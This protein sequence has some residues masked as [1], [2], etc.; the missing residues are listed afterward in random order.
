LN[1]LHESCVKG[2]EY[3][4]HHGYVSG[5]SIFAERGKEDVGYIGDSFFPAGESFRGFAVKRQ[6]PGN[7]C[8]LAA[9]EDGPVQLGSTKLPRFT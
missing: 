3:E 8:P 7:N 1:D 5:V 9:A 4:I 2:L 6:R